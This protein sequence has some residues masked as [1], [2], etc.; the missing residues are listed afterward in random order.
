H[1]SFYEQEA[2]EKLQTSPPFKMTEKA[3][4]TARGDL[5]TLARISLPLM[6]YLFCECLTLA[7]ERVF[8]SYYSL[9]AVQGA[10]S[11]LY[12]AAI[13][14]LSTVAI[15]SMAQVFVGYYHGGGERIQIGPCVW[16]LIWFSLLSSLLVLPL[17][18]LASLWYFKGT[19]IEQVGR[20][21]FKVLSYGNFLFPLNAALTSFYLGR[22]KTVLVSIATITSYGLQLLLSWLLIFGVQGIIPPL[23]AQGAALG[24]CLSLGSLSL[25]FFFLLM[26]KSH[27]DCY[28]TNQW[29]LRPSALWGFIRPGLVR[30]LNQFVIRLY[31]ILYV[32]LILKKGGLYLDVLT[33][34]GLVFAF[35]RF[36]IVGLLQAMLTI[37][38]NLLGK[39]SYHELWRF[40]RSSSLYVGMISGLLFIVLIYFPNVLLC[41]FDPSS[42]ALFTQLFHKI[43]LS[44]WALLT[45]I[46]MQCC[47][48]AALTAMQD[49]KC[50]FYSTLFVSTVPFLSVYFGLKWDLLQPDQIW[51]VSVCEAL[52]F[53]TVYSLRLRLNLATNKLDFLSRKVTPL[54]TN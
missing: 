2:K 29:K 13:F 19:A 11:G 36:I 3:C 16:Q 22:G 14:Q 49:L 27:R 18:H 45:L 37:T 47:P 35:F 1:G 21:Y 10:L 25:F 42:K 9:E 20:E 7:S 46:F 30:A 31:W 34:G 44:M 50:Q 17:S 23:G 41:F 24:Q 32:S 5:R 12:L 51:I 54:K 53:A 15:A 38:S 6:F 4:F 48:L 28:Q 40:F 52:I 8:L 26:R 33:V 43:N 39:K